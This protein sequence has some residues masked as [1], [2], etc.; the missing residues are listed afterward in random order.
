MTTH[1]R[2]LVWRIPWTEEPGVLQSRGLQRVRHNWLTHTHSFK[3]KTYDL[4]LWTVLIHC[5]TF[6]KGFYF[7]MRVIYIHSVCLIHY[8]LGRKK[9]H[10]KNKCILHLCELIPVCI[11]IDSVL[12][13]TLQLRLFQEIENNCSLTCSSPGLYCETQ[14]GLV[15]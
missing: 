13:Q 11:A 7:G 2:I 3:A 4:L 1:S 15:S 12:K 14:S 5:A 9:N 6:T 10:G 8:S